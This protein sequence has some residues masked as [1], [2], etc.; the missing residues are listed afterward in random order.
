MFQNMKIKKKLIISFIIVSILASVSGI[1]GF[2][3][4]IKLNNDY[5]KALVENGFVQGDLGKFNTS[6]NK[7]SALVRD[8]IYLTDE[9]ELQQTS[10]ELDELKVKTDNALAALRVNCQT[11]EELELIKIIDENLPLYQQKRQQT[12]DLGL[13]MKN[14]EAL[15]L[16]RQEA[17]PYL[18]KCV[19]AIEQ[20]IELNVSMG[21]DISQSLNRQATA[22]Q[23]LIVLVI[24]G[25][26]VLSVFLGIYVSGTISR[27][28]T[29]CSD[30]L[31][32]LA[33]G[34]FHSSVMESSAR[35]EAG[36]MLLAM[37]TTTESMQKVI[38][39][40][41]Y[42][43][44]ELAEGNLNIDA[45]VDYPGDFDTIKKSILKIKHSLNSA[46]SEINQSAD[47][48]SS[49]SDQVSS[50]AQA[51]SQG[52]TEQAS[53]VE[54]LAATI[55]EISGQVQ[56]NAQNAAT[57]KEGANAVGENMAQSSEQMQRMKHAMNEISNS[58]NEISK[59][60]KTIEDIAFQTNI[61]AL[62]AAIEA[63]RAGAAGKGFAVVADEVRNLASK[64]GEASKDTAVLIENSL[65]AVENGTELADATA[66]SL[67]VAVEGAKRVIEDINKISDASTEQANSIAQVT[68]GIDQISAVVQ[69]NSATA[70]QSAAASEE[71]SGQA[72][73]LKDLVGKF[74]LVE[75]TNQFSY[76]EAAPQQYVSS[77]EYSSAP[78]NSILDK[79]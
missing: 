38:Q 46:L 47:Q 79:Y 57:A 62:N 60:I 2:F 4:S 77:E 75:E 15:K 48:V 37:K 67:L 78:R 26:L 58:S 42:A 49:G 59:I 68:Q 22:F 76:S 9:A 30:R 21:N 50:G 56:S 52:A 31:Q 25:A 73:I 24:I 69:T 66:D 6:L 13:A 70:Q 3:V 43:L 35:D 20:L 65:K 23:T 64:S 11:P 5:S 1:V 19:D 39:D 27:L 71:L 28:I 45:K 40:I 55:T 34:D 16:F 36:L 29:A 53:S 14:D 61:L 74:K 51:L 44:G 18:N 17:R 12:I 7:G 63:A 54:E 41:D 72:Q 10:K 8:M 32:L 33:K